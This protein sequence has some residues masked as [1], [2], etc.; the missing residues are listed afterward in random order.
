MIFVPTHDQ[1]VTLSV[2]A[3]LSRFSTLPETRGMRDWLRDE[4][5]RLD[6]ANRNEPD[7][8]AFRQRQGACQVIQAIFTAIET[9]DRTAEKI[10]ANQRKP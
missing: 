3:S 8:V 6:A 5:G 4:L 7:E 2:L 10:R 1:N 9:A